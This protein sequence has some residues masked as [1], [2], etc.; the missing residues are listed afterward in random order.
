MKKILVALI[1]VSVFVKWLDSNSQPA[2]TNKNDLASL[3]VTYNLIDTKQALMFQLNRRY[4]GGARAFFSN[5]V[6]RLEYPKAML[7]NCEFGMQELSF[8]VNSSGTLSNIE[9]SNANA[10]PELAKV[11][12]ANSQKWRPIALKLPYT[13]RINLLYNLNKTYPITYPGKYIM[14]PGYSDAKCDHATGMVKNLM[15]KHSEKN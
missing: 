9:C 14:I 13:F 11:L 1:I 6:D 2:Q 10:L 5:L 12:Q 7:Q 15:E 4:K 8:T 3:R